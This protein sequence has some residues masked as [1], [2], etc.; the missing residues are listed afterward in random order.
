LIILAFFT[1]AVFLGAIVRLPFFA[2]RT[3]GFLPF[4]DPSF[5]LIAPWAMARLQKIDA[6]RKP[7]R[8]KQLWS[9]AALLV[10]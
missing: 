3:A 5:D 9:S 1:K 6:I 2:A 7:I 10:S 8:L 4:V